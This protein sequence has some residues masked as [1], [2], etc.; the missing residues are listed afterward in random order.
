MKPARNKSV[1]IFGF[2]NEA[3]AF[4]RT[5]FYDQPKA[6]LIDAREKARDLPK[7]NFELG[8]YF[9]DEGKWHDALFRFRMTLY[10]RKDY[11]QALYNLGYCHYQLGHFDKASSILKQVL[12]QTP[13]H[14]DAAFLLS[15]IDPNAV[16]PAQR[17]QTTPRPMLIA[18][19]SGL[20]KDY[21][22]IEAH[23]QYR[24]GVTVAEQV[25]P[26]LPASD[27]SLV[28]L[29]CGTGIAS[30]PYR[31]IAKRMVGVDVTPAIVAQA[32]TEGTAEKKL[33]EE[34]IEAD[35]VSLGD[36]LEANA[37]DLALLVNVAQFVGALETTIAGAAKVLKTG[38][39]LAMTV[40]PYPRAEGFGIVE[41]T[42]RFGH[43]DAYVKQVANAAGLEVVKTLEV[44]LYPETSAELLIFRK[45]SR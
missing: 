16:A 28:D 39:H 40:E 31:S 10:F 29:G 4:L 35:L 45:G 11:P 44:A 3:E 26:L 13:S 30:I 24:G 36:R 9:A 20:A 25:K 22:Q 27:I 37:A 6:W 12:R 19:F 33:F 21:N 34:V 42:G 32:R 23:N 8:C 43:S 5:T 18:F 7:T 41:K 1:S 14:T 15:S 38:G 17:P 2:V